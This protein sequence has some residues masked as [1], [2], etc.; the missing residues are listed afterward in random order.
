MFHRSNLEIARLCD[1]R[2]AAV[3]GDYFVFGNMPER[4][5][6][7]P[8]EETIVFR[9]SAEAD[10]RH[11]GLEPKA[12]RGESGTSPSRKLLQD[13]VLAERPFTIAQKIPVSTQILTSTP[14][15]A[16]A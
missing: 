2:V 9:G 6:H 13:Y 15:A 8:A 14:L 1:E 10:I 11:T 7:S 4:L 12:H 5:A 16:K 3:S